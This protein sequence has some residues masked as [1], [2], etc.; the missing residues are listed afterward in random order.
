MGELVGRHRRGVD[1][2]GQSPACSSALIGS[3]SAR[4]P[5]R[6]SRPAARGRTACCRS[7]TARRDIGRADA[8]RIIARTEAAR[9]SLPDDRWPPAGWRTSRFAA[10]RRARRS[11]GLRPPR[12]P[13]FITPAVRP[14]RGGDRRAGHG[15]ALRRHAVPR[16]LRPQTAAAAAGLRRVVRAHRLERRPPAARAGDRCCSPRPG[17]SSPST[18]CAGGAPAAWWAGVLIIAGAMA[19][20]PADAGAANYAH[21]ALLPGTAASSGRGAARCWAVAAGVALGVWRSSAGRA[22]CWASSRRVRQRWPPVD[23]ATS[24][25][26]AGAAALIVATTGLYAPL[27]GFWE[28]NVANSPGFVFAGTG[29]G[30]AIGRGA[31]VGCSGSSASIP[32]L[33]G[34]RR[35][36]RGGATPP[37]GARAL[38]GDLDLWIWVPPGSPRGRRPALLRPLLAA[39]VPPLV[40]LAAPVAAAGPAGGGWPFAGVAVPAR[41]LRAAVRPRLVPSPTRPDRAGGSSTPTTRRRP[42]PRLGLVPGGAGRRRPGSR[43]AAGAQRLRHRPHRWPHDPAE[44]LAGDA[45][46]ARRSCCDSLADHPPS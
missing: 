5:R 36:R 4:P 35:R 11:A 8:S 23:G 3:P 38:P 45:R 6:S 28:W 13:T 2:R 46:S 7:R 34:L 1:P 22:G 42:R 10:V 43:P 27:G 30:A 15:R 40:V 32:H 37:S 16:H 24:C 44:T 21:F 31:G 18:A 39:G 29:F 20:F 19:L 25:R 12:A 17:S 33:G 41:R 14:R 26:V 9:T